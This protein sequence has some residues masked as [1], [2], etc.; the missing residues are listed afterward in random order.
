MR[1][2]VFIFALLLAGCSD[3]VKPLTDGNTTEARTE[4][5][6][7]QIGGDEA[8]IQDEATTVDTAADANQ[9]EPTPE[10][11]IVQ[12]LS[13]VDAP[14]RDNHSGETTPERV[15]AETTPEPTP[16]PDTKP[17]QLPRV[18]IKA[19]EYAGAFR[20][21]SSKQGES[22]INYSNN[23][24]AYN[25]K[26]NSL[27]IVGHNHQQAI[28]ELE[29]PKIVKST[30]LSALAE[31]KKFLQPFYKI[32]GRFTSGVTL[33]YFAI[34]G[35][36]FHNNKII[37][38]YLNWYDAAGKLQKTTFV[39]DDATKLKTTKITGP[40]EMTGKN[41]SG[42]WISEIPAYWQQKLG[43]THLSG[44]SNFA[45]I[46]GRL[47]VGVSAYAFSP[48]KE[49]IGV[50]PKKGKVPAT[51]LLDFDLKNPLY[52]KSVYSKKPSTNDLLYNKDKKNKLF[53]I[54]SSAAYGFIVPGTRT[55]MTIG[56]SAGHEHG[57][58]YKIR[59]DTG[60]LCGGPC[61]KVASDRYNYYWLWDVEDLIKVKNGK[62][63]P[64]DVRPYA[65]GKFATPFTTTKP[66]NAATYDKKNKRLFIALKEAD[67][68][69]YSVKP[70]ILVYNVKVP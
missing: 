12:D 25:E 57:L 38:H 26:N 14:P 63:K 41:H 68:V 7:E 22:S 70:I 46:I 36:Y 51:V 65:F 39:V 13:P 62:M 16:Q 4:L 9:P 1:I 40:Y 15:A 11:Q 59:Q 43:G 37:A 8:Q 29:I 30:K 53:T 34:K 21:S 3:P 2:F 17:G 58:G 60:R 42:G 24:M 31:A 69:G 33:N 28:A 6:T 5:T 10:E 48:L 32:H 45:S 44:A 50:D 56:H 55:Y 66:I 35:M 20:V 54:N 49:I 47:C 52:D 67:K 19:L 23:A 18:G 27:Y 64:Y 61:P